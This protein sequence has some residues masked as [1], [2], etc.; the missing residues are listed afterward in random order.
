MS[1]DKQKK[2]I[3]YTTKDL[4][5]M[6]YQWGKVRVVTDES[7]PAFLETLAYL[8]NLCGGELPDT[9][10]LCG[11]H[12]MSVNCNNANCEETRRFL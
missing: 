5:D 10:M 2:L 12:P 4:F 9:C 6:V 8:V 1:D 7:S 11:S 3:E